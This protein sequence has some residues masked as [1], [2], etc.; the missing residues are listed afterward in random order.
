MG[1]G[2]EREAML[3]W[4]QRAKEVGDS[5]GWQQLQANSGVPELSIHLAVGEGNLEMQFVEV[6]ISQ[7]QQNAEYSQYK[8]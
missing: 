7:A 8:P 3:L 2:R 4:S 1:K 5:Q 6:G